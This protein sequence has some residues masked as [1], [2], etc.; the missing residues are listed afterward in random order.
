MSSGDPPPTDNNSGTNVASAPRD[1]V[2]PE[3]K[4]LIDVPLEQ[5]ET[6]AGTNV[7]RI[8]SGDIQSFQHFTERRGGGQRGQHLSDEEDEEDAP[9]DERMDAV[10]R[11]RREG[12][13]S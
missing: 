11:R 8:P 12:Q 3:T 5:Q 2:D 4:A 9:W 7:P 10:K 6:I 13:R 1:P